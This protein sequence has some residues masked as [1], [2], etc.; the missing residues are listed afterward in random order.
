[1]IMF[2]Q[3]YESGWTQPT[4][5]NSADITT[6]ASDQQPPVIVAPFPSINL[7]SIGSFL[8]QNDTG[9]GYL[10]WGDCFLADTRSGDWNDLSS[11]DYAQLFNGVTY[12]QPWVLHNHKE[13]HVV[14]R[15]I[16]WSSLDNY[17]VS[18][19]AATTSPNPTVG[20]GLR[21]K[22]HSI[23]PGHHHTSVLVAGHGINATLMAWGDVLLTNGGGKERAKV[24]DDFV[25][26]HLGFWTDNGAYFYTGKHDNYTNMQEALLAVKQSMNSSGIPIRYMQ[27][28]DWW[29]VCL[30]LLVVDDACSIPCPRT[31]THYSHTQQSKGDIPGMLSWTPK[32]DVFPSGFSDWLG[33]PL[34]L[35]APQYSGENV[36]NNE[37]VWKSVD[38]KRGRTSIPLD[39]NFYMH[40]FRNGTRI[41][42]KF[43]EQDFLC[44]YGIGSTGLTSTDVYSGKEWFAFM[45]DAALSLDV[46]L[47]F[48]MPQAYHLLQSTTIHSVTNARATGDNTR[49]YPSIDSMG[50]NTLL[51]YALGVFASRDNVWTSNADVEQPGC[52]NA[53]FCYEPNAPLDNV[54]A[55]LSGGP[56]GIA[57]AVGYSNKTLV[58]YSCRTDGVMLRP[59]WPLASL[60]FTF[61]AHDAK[62]S[63]VWVAHDDFGHWRWSYIV[64]VDLKKEVE[65]TPK[66]LLQGAICSCGKKMVAW[67]VVVGEPVAS[68][69]P[70]SD[71]SPFMIPKSKPLNLPY[72]VTAP[73]H[74]HYA[75]APVL[76]NGMVFLGEVYKW[77]TMSFGRVKS[78]D[79][80]DDLLVDIVAAP[81]EVVTFAYM[82]DAGA[83]E[84]GQVKCKFAPKYSEFDQHMNSN[85]HARIVCHQSSGCM[86][87]GSEVDNHLR[88]SLVMSTK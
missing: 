78:L 37:Y 43:F 38:T 41:G 10:L 62:G 72:N 42:M 74:T 34:A 18:G 33:M 16:V 20:V 3:V 64:G 85:C 56:Y 17:F 87:I 60:D 55:V 82:K 83:S 76:P 35:Y 68:V 49:N 54:V 27:W 1:M 28:D 79:V 57:D 84:I 11:D 88:G 40:L 63:K 19:F 8:P 32:S 6:T 13:D 52:G 2:E 61:T 9:L 24:Y 77:A 66:R 39:P 30:C 51:F 46:T 21:T 23:P 75:T 14:S 22:L 81:S 15:A 50:L 31:L 5:N 26:S 58:M 59:R 12:G 36:W 7:T 25:L 4:N 86:C 67:K 45:D 29:M 44:E 70:F 65:I 71:A 48:C 47:Q 80:A 53:N 73:A 69:V